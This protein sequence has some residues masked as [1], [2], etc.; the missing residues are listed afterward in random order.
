MRFL[1]YILPLLILSCSLEY[2]PVTPVFSDA[3]SLIDGLPPIDTTQGSV[4]NGVYAV[5]FGRA[6]FGDSVAMHFAIGGPSIFC[7]KNGAFMIMESAEHRDTIVME[8]YWRFA[9]GRET[10]RVRFV[11]LPS[12][13][14]SAVARGVATDTIILRGRMGGATGPLERPVE[15]EW[16]RPLTKRARTFLIIGHRGGGRN[17]DLHPYSENSLPMLRFA[18]RLGCNGV[19]IDIRL[20]SDG[21]PILFHDETISNRLVKGDFLVGPISAYSWPQLRKYA[22]LLNGEPIPLFDDALKTIVEETTLEF[23]WLDIKAPEVLPII[24]PIVDKYN[25]RAKQL[26]RKVDLLMGLPTEE[27]YGSYKAIP[28]A[29]RPGS[30]CELD[31]DQ[32]S[33]INASAWGPRWT[34]GLQSAEVSRMHAEGRRVVTWTV[35][36]QDLLLEFLRNGDFDGMVT[37]YPTVVFATA[38]IGRE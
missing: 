16:I 17:S 25:K 26:G 5:R 20:T 11:I 12:E 38:E 33:S 24:L 13:G 22:R 30:L 31:P 35:D 18:E 14:G 28:E 27:I 9:Y 3:E 7:E 36:A 4:L 1:A 34:L 8:G 19:E 15:L 32:T 6:D 37:N 21:V 29:D 2:E 23:V 10:G